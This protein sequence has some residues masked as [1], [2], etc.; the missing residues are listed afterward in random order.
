MSDKKPPLY[1]TATGKKLHLIECPHV[2]GAE[3]FEAAAGTHEICTWCLAELSGEG[4]TYHASIEDALR[5]MGAPEVSIPELAR[6]LRPVAHDSVYVP[7]S[8]AYVALA[9][10]GLGVAWA[11]QTYVAFRDAPTVLLPDYVAAQVGAALG[12]RDVWGETCEVHF[13]K[14]SVDGTCGDCL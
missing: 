2:H 14:R 4:R 7:F 11:G 5:D 9:L 3:L 8:R 12:L 13:I 10:D 6:H 1:R